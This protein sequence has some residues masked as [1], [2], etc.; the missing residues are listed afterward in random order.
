MRVGVVFPQDAAGTDAGAIAAFACG[1]ED[2][3]FAYLSCYDHVVGASRARH[4]LNGPYDE[5]SPFHEPL[6]LFG[7]LAAVTKRVGLATGV[8]VLPQRQTALVAKQAAE[9]A[10]LSG[11]R[12]ILGVGVGWNHVE[13]QCLGQQFRSRGSRIEEQVQLLRALWDKP[14]VEFSGR[15]DQIPAA[16]ILPRPAQP[17]PIWMGGWSD[18][19]L[20]RIGRLADGWMTAAGHPATLRRLPADALA[21]R[22]TSADRLHE[23]LEL[24]N[25]AAE[26]AGRDPEAI[27]VCISVPVNEGAQLLDAETIAESVRVWHGAGVSHV[28]LT[29]QDATL[30]FPDGHLKFLHTVSE[31]LDAD[32][33]STSN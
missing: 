6:V 11:G 16:G 13:Y 21:N 3:G 29:F 23:R 14:L 26:R 12:L 1:V 20:D 19:V 4:D 17:I 5:N 7:Y 32:R 10:L 15:F 28:S 8:L 33:L 18:T 30:P 27:N 9:V 22:I 25:A 2:L 24:I 31:A